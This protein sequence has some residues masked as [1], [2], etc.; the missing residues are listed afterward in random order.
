MHDL[1][2]SNKNSQLS[3][4]SG[5][6]RSGN[7][8]P[9]IHPEEARLVKYPCSARNRLNV[10]TCEDEGNEEDVKDVGGLGMLD[11]N[12]KVVGGMLPKF[13][14]IV[15]RDMFKNSSY[16][17]PSGIVGVMFNDILTKRIASPWGYYG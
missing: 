15:P 9:Y 6:C 8:S 13:I 11:V 14:P 12:L 4:F 17:I 10:V 1:N 2:S 16:D 5:M 3:L 7:F